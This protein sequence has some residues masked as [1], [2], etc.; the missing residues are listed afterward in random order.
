MSNRYSL[1]VFTTYSGSSSSS[2]ALDISPA[3]RW[4]ANNSLSTSRSGY[5]DAA[6]SIAARATSTW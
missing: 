6:S 4:N 2:S 1:S 5:S 3:N